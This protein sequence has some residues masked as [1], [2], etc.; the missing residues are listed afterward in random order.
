MA[1]S[2]MKS[3]HRPLF[4]NHKVPAKGS[5]DTSRRAFDAYVKPQDIPPHKAAKILS[6]LN[7]FDSGEQLMSLIGKDATRM[8]LSPTDAKRILR[9][10][11]DLGEFRDLRQVKA[12]RG[13]GP[14]KFNFIV[15]V[16]SG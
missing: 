15:N 8:I 2:W 12:V 16:L 10:K 4:R 13:V 6:K 1:R 5:H 14:K 7:S 11:Q 3:S 9:K